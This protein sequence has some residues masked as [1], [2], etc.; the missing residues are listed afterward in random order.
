MALDNQEQVLLEK[1]KMK[2][3][4]DWRESHGGEAE[5][6]ILLDGE[7][8]VALMITDAFYQAE[9]EL[10]HNPVSSTAILSEY[11]HTLLESVSEEL[12][13]AIEE[14]CGRRIREIVPLIDVRA[15][16]VI[17]FFSF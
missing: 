13:P 3:L 4:A 15:G 10:S 16:W 17:A 11:L 14:F 6:A 12:L 7:D 8:G 1:I 5:K 9:I 2:I